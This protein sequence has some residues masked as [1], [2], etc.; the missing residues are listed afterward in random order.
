MTLTALDLSVNQINGIG[1]SASGTNQI[2]LQSNSLYYIS[3]MLRIAISTPTTASV[4]FCELAPF[5]NNG[6]TNMNSFSY[7]NTATSPTVGAITINGSGLLPTGAGPQLLD[8]RLAIQS[9]TSGATFSI[10][11]NRNNIS[12]IQ[13]M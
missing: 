10:F 4:D 12:I 1:I 2:S 9:A 7:K 11:G 6:I 8:F 13:I 5:L 3:Y